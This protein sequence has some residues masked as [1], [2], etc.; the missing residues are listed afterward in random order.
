MAYNI[1][2]VNNFSSDFRRILDQDVQPR[3]EEFDKVRLSKI[4]LGIF[5]SLMLFALSIKIPVVISII[6]IVIYW[7]GII[8]LYETQSKKYIPVLVQLVPF[9]SYFD[10]SVLK[11]EDLTYSR[12]FPKTLASNSLLSFHFFDS[13]TGAINRVNV[14]ISKFVYSYLQRS[15]ALCVF[16]GI[17]IRVRTKNYAQGITV[18]RPRNSKYFNLSDLLDDNFEKVNISDMVFSSQYAIY[19]NNQEEAK[20]LVNH[21]FIKYFSQFVKKIKS[22]ISY[23]AFCGNYMYMALT[24]DA[25]FSFTNIFKS[26]KD[27]NAFSP[28]YNTFSALIDIVNGLYVIEDDDS[29]PS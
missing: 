7:A 14:D 21:K 20:Q 22:P 4:H 17:V 13:F 8:Y 19:S 28:I 23:C 9:L 3:M 24:V 16:S 6:L 15:S 18:L 1:Y 26:V 2:T 25:G 11:L 29:R 12:L 5:L 10:I 27:E